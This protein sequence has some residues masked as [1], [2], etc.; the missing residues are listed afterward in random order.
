MS[1]FI[2]FTEKIQISAEKQLEATSL[3]C[4]VVVMPAGSSM[5]SVP[6]KTTMGCFS[7]GRRGAIPMG[8]GSF[9]LDYCQV[10]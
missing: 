1:C 9:P 6:A 5:G 2:P 10:G 3:T 7:E 8:S 4:V